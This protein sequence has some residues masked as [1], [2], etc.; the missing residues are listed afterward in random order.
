MTAL[1]TAGRGRRGGVVE[2]NDDSEWDC[3]SE[4]NRGGQHEPVSKKNPKTPKN[5]PENE[6]EG[7]KED[8]QNKDTDKNMNITTTDEDE[9]E[10]EE[11]EE[12]EEE[13]STREN[14]A[15]R[16]GEEGE[17]KENREE[18]NTTTE[19]KTAPPTSTS[20]I[21]NN[22]NNNT[23]T[24]TT[25][26]S[27]EGEVEGSQRRKRGRPK[28][29]DVYESVL[30]Y[31]RRLQEEKEKRGAM[32]ALLEAAEEDTDDHIQK[33]GKKMTATTTMNGNKKSLCNTDVVNDIHNN[34]NT[35]NGDVKEEY[36]L[37]GGPDISGIEKLAADALDN[38]LPNASESERMAHIKAFMMRGA[39]GIIQGMNGQATASQTLQQEKQQEEKNEK[40]HISPGKDYTRLLEAKRKNLSKKQPGKRKEG[41][42]LDDTDISPEQANLHKTYKEALQRMRQ[43]N[44]R[45][46][47]EQKHPS[48][49]NSNVL[50]TVAMA[51]YKL[52]EKNL[53][54]AVLSAS[55]EAK[56]RESSLVQGKL[57]K[58]LQQQLQQQL[59][60]QQELSSFPQKQEE[61]KKLLSLQ[62]LGSQV[63]LQS[64]PQFNANA[65][66][67]SLLA[68][69]QGG[70][71]G[72]GT[73]LNQLTQ[74]LLMQNYVN[75]AAMNLLNGPGLNSAG[76]DGA[77][78]SAGFSAPPPNISSSK[79]MNNSSSTKKSARGG[80]RDMSSSVF[81]TSVN[82]AAF[83]K[84]VGVI[85]EEHVKKVRKKI[86][87]KLELSE[88][89]IEKELKLL[90]DGK[91][92]HAAF[93]SLLSSF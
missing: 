83:K 36:Q 27:K 86:A 6:K 37:K 20:N 26:S 38:I 45:K 32:R 16:I 8:A 40:S 13:T 11:E 55:K 90:E 93:C 57:Q 17:E 3:D 28:K 46:S 56:R 71:L 78:I 61:F 5:V 89:A 76:L 74:N 60:Q 67:S 4:D 75:M 52:R 34:I 85:I 22:N 12:E 33:K 50:N 30:Q 81:M 49:K 54:A 35:T 82:S 10:E 21:N 79:K 19:I 92:L 24:T 77:G 9:D 1:K 65:G 41:N 44:V 51:Q 84:H 25:K 23:T 91:E 18:G 53:A 39:N 80:D 15:V 31:E 72:G 59:W 29:N 63:G 43:E 68:G 2:K 66:L 62:Q 64:Q 73:E 88:A 70:L 7:E 69:G 87:L 14:N 42:V 48:S 47:R 58:N